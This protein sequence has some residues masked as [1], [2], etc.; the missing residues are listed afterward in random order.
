MTRTYRL[1]FWAL[2]VALAVTAVGLGM[3]AMPA[4][5][6]ATG[7]T[8][9]IGNGRYQPGVH[10]VSTSG[11][12]GSLAIGIPITYLGVT[13]ILAWMFQ[14]IITSQEGIQYVNRFGREEMRENW[15]AF[16]SLQ[17][18]SSPKSGI[19]YKATIA[20]RTLPITNLYRNYEELIEEITLN[21]PQ[22]A[23][24]PGS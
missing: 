24:M 2:L 7:T 5:K 13:S 11:L 21:A 12:W 15:A 16:E 6:L 18:R 10:P 14:R 22:V 17:R 9:M 19:T 4:V 23:G 3:V 8:M 20:G 1:N